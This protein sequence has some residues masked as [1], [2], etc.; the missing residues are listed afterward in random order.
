MCRFS[1]SVVTV[2]VE[3]IHIW[4]IHVKDDVRA[5]SV[6]SVDSVIVVGGTLIDSVRW[7][8]VQRR[9]TTEDRGRETE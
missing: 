7:G 5:C 2:M 1:V 3:G 8:I 9:T 6:N 4:V